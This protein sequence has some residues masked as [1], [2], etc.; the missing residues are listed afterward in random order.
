MLNRIPRNICNAEDVQSAFIENLQAKRSELTQTTKTEMGEISGTSTPMVGKKRKTANLVSSDSES[1]KDVVCNDSS[2]GGLSDFVAEDEE[3]RSFISNLE[4]NHT[5]II[6]Q[7]LP[8]IL[9]ISLHLN[10]TA[11]YILEK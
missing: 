9:E 5:Q 11:K 10:T 6:L 1:P 4:G 8:R 7:N 3:E 2:D